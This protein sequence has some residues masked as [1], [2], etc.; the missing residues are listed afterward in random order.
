MQ[1]AEGKGDDPIVISSFVGAVV[2]ERA[3]VAV[4]GGSAC[5]H[6]DTLKHHLPPLLVGLGCLLPHRGEVRDRPRF[7][8]YTVTPG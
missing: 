3:M 4:D 5:F 6:G 8:L 1:L 2:M 7:F